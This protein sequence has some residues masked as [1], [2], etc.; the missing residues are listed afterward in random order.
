MKN[1]RRRNAGRIFAAGFGL[2]ILAVGAGW[3]GRSL[4]I[5]PEN[6]EPLKYICPACLALFGLWIIVRKL[7]GGDGTR[8]GG[9]EAHDAQM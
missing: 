3:L 9:K 4:G 5:L 1:S 2:M 6:F 8:S 7:V